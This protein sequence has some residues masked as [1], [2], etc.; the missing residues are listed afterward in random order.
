MGF[1][2]RLNGQAHVVGAFPSAPEQAKVLDPLVGSEL[3]PKQRWLLLAL[4][5]LRALPE[6]QRQKQELP[7]TFTELRPDALY[8]TMTFTGTFTTRVASLLSP[9]DPG[10]IMCSTVLVLQFPELGL[11]P[12]Q[13]SCRSAP[14][15]ASLQ[16]PSLSLGLAGRSP[17]RSTAC[18][19]TALRHGFRKP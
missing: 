7:L 4:P 6:V 13:R 12:L 11:G 19:H 8:F 2:R 9:S 16:K 15:T 5:L 14:G 3:A 17:W 18:L 1:R 10:M